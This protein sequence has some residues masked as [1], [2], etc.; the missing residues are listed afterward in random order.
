MKKLLASKLCLIA[1]SLTSTTA[2]AHTGHLSNDAVH[3]MLHI[4]HIIAITIG[5]IAY[6][7]KVSRRK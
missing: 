2:F 7:A 3:G 6:Y 5:L 1:F 4:E